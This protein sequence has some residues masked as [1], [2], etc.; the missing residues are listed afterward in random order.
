MGEEVGELQFKF[1]EQTT[2]ESRTAVF[3]A[4]YPDVPRLPQCHHPTKNISY[5]ASPRQVPS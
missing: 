2:L 4:R 3:R 5:I 1:E